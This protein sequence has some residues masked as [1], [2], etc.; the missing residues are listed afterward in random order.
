MTVHRVVGGIL[1]VTALLLFTSPETNTK[2]VT[3]LALVGA[4]ALGWLG[5]A[6]LE[7]IAKG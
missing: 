4:F 2:L 3:G 7:C 5:A 6:L 1:A